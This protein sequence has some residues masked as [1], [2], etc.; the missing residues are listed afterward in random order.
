MNK[1]ILIG[2]LV[3]DPEVGSSKNGNM[4]A[5]FTLAVDR[6]NARSDSNLQQTDFIR[7]QSWGNNAN[8]AQTYLRKGTKILVEGQLNINQYKNDQNQNMSFTQVSVSS[9]EFVESKRQD[10]NSDFNTFNPMQDNSS[11]SMNPT[12]D[13][14]IRFEDFSQDDFNIETENDIDFIGK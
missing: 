5:N 13:D 14:E 10:S 3:A 12:N 8:F 4:Y 1:V 2:R 11:T 7:C 6:R 9:F